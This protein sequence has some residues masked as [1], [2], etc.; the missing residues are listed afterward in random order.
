MSMLSRQGSLA[1]LLRGPI[2]DLKAGL[3]LTLPEDMQVAI[4]V[5]MMLQTKQ[6]KMQVGSSTALAPKLRSESAVARASAV[7][8][9]VKQVGKQV[10]DR[11]VA[12]TLKRETD[13]AQ[14]H[15]Y[16]LI[17]AAR[18]TTLIDL[19]KPGFEEA[20][21]DLLSLIAAHPVVTDPTYATAV[22]Q[23]DT[24][25]LEAFQATDELINRVA[26][27]QGVAMKL[28]NDWK[29]REDYPFLAE[30]DPA[31][32]SKEMRLRMIGDPY[33]RSSGGSPRAMPDMREV[34]ASGGVLRL[35]NGLELKAAV[36]AYD[37]ALRQGQKDRLAASG[38][39]RGPVG[40]FSW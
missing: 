25:V 29:L 4:D 36:Q 19:M 20:V 7:D 2:N 39:R 35:L 18:K 30:W 10:V 1:S 3:G 8:N 9:W 28:A 21:S 16:L 22:K 27:M 12:K 37:D 17:K 26:Y 32:I 14:M 11:E 15:A 24:G 38:M 5:A 13:A 33:A 34:L 23:R 6:K 40:T 31:T